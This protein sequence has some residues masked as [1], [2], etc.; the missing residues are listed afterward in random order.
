MAVA[1]DESEATGAKRDATIK[2]R[3]RGWWVATIV[4]DV[5]RR[6]WTMAF[7]GVG[8]VRWHSTETAMVRRGG[9]KMTPRIE[10]KRRM[11]DSGCQTAVLA[12][13]DI[14]AI[15]LHHPSAMMFSTA[16]ALCHCPTAG[17]NEPRAAAIVAIDAA[18]SQ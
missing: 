18:E 15:I 1:M 14:A 12:V 2:S 5:Q 13:V 3:Q 11:A 9:S 10:L 8:D 17:G 16:A 7:E 4:I 6:K